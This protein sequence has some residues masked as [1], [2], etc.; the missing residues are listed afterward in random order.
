MVVL[1][2][3][4]IAIWGIPIGIVVVLAVWLWMSAQALDP[5]APL[6]SPKQPLR[7]EVVGYDWKWLFIYPDLGIAS[8]GEFA[9]PADRPL[10]IELTSGASVL[11][12]G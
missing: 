5:Y 4:E 6:S 8:I 11:P 9:I 2:A 7:I 10:A 3:L 12:S 1:S